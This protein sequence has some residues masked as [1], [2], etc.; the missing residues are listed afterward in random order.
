MSCAVGCR[1][2]SDAMLLWLWHRPAATAPIR[3]LCW[4]PPHAAG[5]ALEKAKRRKK[6]KIPNKYSINVCWTDL[7]P[8]LGISISARYF[9]WLTRP[10]W[11]S[12]FL[13]AEWSYSRNNLLGSFPIKK[14]KS[15]IILNIKCI[16]ISQITNN[17]LSNLNEERKGL[18]GRI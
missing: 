1:L 13:S 18:H 14:A 8:M 16:L 9:R 6:K 4:E 5:A 17:I 7:C 15:Y 2:G 3:P 11:D 12:S 10:L